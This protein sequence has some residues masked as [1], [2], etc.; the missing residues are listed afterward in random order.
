MSP[1][2]RP[3][4]LGRGLAL[5]VYVFNCSSQMNIYTLGDIFKGL[6]QS[7]GWGCFDEF[8]RIPIEVLSVVSNQ[9]MTILQALRAQVPL[10]VKQSRFD[11]MG[12]DIRIISTV[13][14]FIT[15]NP[16]YAGRTELPESLKALFR[17]CAMVV[18]DFEMIC[19]NMLM[20]EGFL[21]ARPLA[22]KIVTLYRLGADLLSKQAQYDWGLRA[23]KSGAP[24]V[25]APSA[26]WQHFN[27]ASRLHDSVA[28]SRW[29]EAR[30]EGGCRGLDHDARA[31]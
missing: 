17:P 26:L 4:D 5:P 9:V 14:V 6:C 1:W 29:S 23:I 18:P 19:E 11:F 3:Q 10:K 15:M 31:S 22:K 24:F 28:R 7:G 13:G 8:N 2:S 21:S 25:V 30:R 12:D 16:G 20:S 27:N